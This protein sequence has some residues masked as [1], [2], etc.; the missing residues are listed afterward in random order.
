MSVTTGVRTAN[1]QGAHPVGMTGCVRNAD[2][3]SLRH[4]EQ[5]ETAQVQGVSER[6][7]IAHHCFER[8]V[9]GIAIGKAGAALVVADQGAANAELAKEVA[10]DRAQPVELEVTEPMGGTDQHGTRAM[11]RKREPHPVSRS[12]EPQLLRALP[13]P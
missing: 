12:D 6:F 11:T 10:P 13:H 4:A 2:G 8:E 3:A 5:R 9:R 1:D 7:E